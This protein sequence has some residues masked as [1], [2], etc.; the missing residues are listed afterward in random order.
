[1]DPTEHALAERGTVIL[2]GG[3]STQLERAGADL[4]GSLWTA[5]VLVEDPEAIFHAHRVFLDAGADVLITASYQVSFEAFAARG[6][7]AAEALRASVAIA[8][9]AAESRPDRTAMVAASVG[10]YG[11]VL[12]DGSEYRGHYVTT[13]AELMEFHRR[14]IEILLD[15]GPDLLAIETIPSIAE[16]QALVEVLAGLPDARAWFAFT[17]AD[18][19]TLAD[20]TP[21]VEAV[22]LVA[23]SPQ[24]VAVGVNCTAPAFVADLIRTARGITTKPIVAYPNRGGVWD[25]DAKRWSGPAGGALPD[26]A[27]EW[28]TAGASLIGGCCGTDASDIAEL[29]SAVERHGG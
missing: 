26:L 13:H 11:A 9:R 3:L 22:A 23:E 18:D 19:A 6:L 21:Y 14:R 7:D 8:R 25:P 27:P 16:A 4:G 24:V 5:N 10:P 29:A 15:A 28:R 1:M 17:C 2:D 12:A 20:G